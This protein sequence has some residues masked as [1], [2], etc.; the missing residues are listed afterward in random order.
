MNSIEY[1]FATKEEEK[2]DCRTGIH[3]KKT[4]YKNKKLLNKIEEEN[5]T[6]PNPLY[7]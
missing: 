3:K 2:N 4:K 6:H 5:I 7:G 1:I